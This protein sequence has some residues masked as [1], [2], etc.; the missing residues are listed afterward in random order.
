MKTTLTCKNCSTENPFYQLTCTKCSA[1]LREKVFNIDLWEVIATIIESPSKAY[2]RIIHSEHK[3]FII[4]ILILAAIKFSIN[5]IYL[6]LALLGE[7][8]NT[9]NFLILIL[10][11]TGYILLSAV[12]SSFFY[13]KALSSKTRFRDNLAIIIYS[14]LPYVFAL[15]ILLPFELILFGYTIFSVNPSPFVVKETLAYVMLSFEGLFIFWALFLSYMAFRRQSSDT[16]I[17]IIFTFI[18]NFLI[19]SALF[20]TAGYYFL[21]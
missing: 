15:V 17:T 16:G 5:A 4:L 2:S 21:L 13:K 11:T 12:I 20:I 7:R 10:I 14:L 9:R 6:S 18:F 1:Y 19:Y 8:H 3:N